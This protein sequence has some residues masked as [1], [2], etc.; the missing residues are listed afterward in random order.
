VII[1]GNKSIANSAHKCAILEGEREREK[2][3]KFIRLDCIL[4]KLFVM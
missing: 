2:K 4:G 1:A 3:A